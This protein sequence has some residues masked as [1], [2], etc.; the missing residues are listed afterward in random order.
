[1]EFKKV[2]Y[3][4]KDFR[5]QS[6]MI[7]S[8]R[9][10]APDMPRGCEQHAHGMS[11]QAAVAGGLSPMI[12]VWRLPSLSVN[13]VQASSRK[14]AGNVIN[15]A[16]W[17]KVSIRLVDGM[18]PE[19]VMEQLKKQLK[20]TTPWGLETTITSEACTGAWSTE[21]SGVAFEAA[22]AALARGYGKE[23]LKIGCGG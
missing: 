4:E 1:K 16:A 19:K 15:D 20:E 3:N 5:A 2:P 11:P 6:G 8:A 17:A 21:S 13:A 14:Q 12:Q 9:L 23:P 22:D 18:N 10:I 7:D